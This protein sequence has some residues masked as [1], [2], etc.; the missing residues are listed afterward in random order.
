VTSG[1][2]GTYPAGLP[3]ATV[4]RIERDAVSAFARI[5]CEPS[6][7]VENNR[8]LLALST[9]AKLLPYP[10]EAVRAERKTKGKGKRRKDVPNVE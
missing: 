9:E 5:V 6:A 10:A 8:Y 4:I 3:V 2:D 7:G 1:I